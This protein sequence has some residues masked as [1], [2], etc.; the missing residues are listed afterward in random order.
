MI[1]RI[2]TPYSRIGTASARAKPRVSVVITWPHDSGH[3]GDILRRRLPQRE[4][5]DFDM[6]VVTTTRATDDVAESCPDIRFITAAAD[7]SVGRMRSLGMQHA[8]G[9]I[10]M[11]I[12]NIFDEDL[13]AA[14]FSMRTADGV[15]VGHGQTASSRE[16]A[17]PTSASEEQAGTA[18]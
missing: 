1:D 13:V 9:N 18:A 17:A 10:V 3:L 2:D 5:S 12:D 8:M 6:I 16:P 7:S 4:R 15:S 14:V 11:M